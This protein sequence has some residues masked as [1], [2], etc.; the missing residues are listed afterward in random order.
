MVLC[1]PDDMKYRIVQA[2][3]FMISENPVDLLPAFSAF[4]LKM[5]PSKFNMISIRRPS[6]SFIKFHS[7]LL[8][9]LNTVSLNVK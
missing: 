4:K 2:L 1:L 3:Q 6:L 5:I 8:K 9:L 7:T